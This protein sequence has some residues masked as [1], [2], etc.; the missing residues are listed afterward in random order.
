M[1]MICL[2]RNLV[3]ACLAFVQHWQSLEHVLQGLLTALSVNSGM[4][5]LIEVK[6]RP[7]AIPENVR[8]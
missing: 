1:F 5:P 6:Q 3:H 8:G 2:Q 4:S 7:A